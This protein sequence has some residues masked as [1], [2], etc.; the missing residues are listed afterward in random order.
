MKQKRVTLW[1]CRAAVAVACAVMILTGLIP[2]IA[3]AE[4]PT[5]DPN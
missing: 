5:Y 4:Q 3:R 2:V 1:Q